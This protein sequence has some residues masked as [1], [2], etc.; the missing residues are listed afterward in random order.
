MLL[1]VISDTHGYVD[2]A[3]TRLF[4]GVHRILHAGDIGA[5]G[6]LEELE[7]I[8][9]VVAVRGNVDRD[10]ALLTL[11]ESIT[12]RLAG[13]ELQVV[14]QLPQARP[15]PETRVLIFGH[16]HRVRCD[17]QGEMLLLNPGA[18]GRQGFHTLRTAALLRLGE[19]PEAEVITLG[20][21]ARG[22]EPAAADR[23]ERT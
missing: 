22:R 16:S 12:M 21:K 2:P 23:E 20:P 9:P 8:A 11:P 4:A 5:H 7:R 6:V 14:H 10:P 3:L 13:V 15:R 19:R 18:A 17:W 1:G